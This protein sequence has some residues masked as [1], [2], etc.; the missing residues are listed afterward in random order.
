MS[1]T[2]FTI[3]TDPKQEA[4][5]DTEMNATETPPPPA[6]NGA[7]TARGRPFEPGTSGNP[8]G[9]PKGHR[10]KATLAMEELLDGDAPALTRKVIERALEG[11]MV[12]M[13]LC[14]DRVMPPRRDRPVAFEL[15]KI[16]SAKDV[17]AAGAAILQA[18]A[19]GALSPGEAA[20]II[21]LLST[22][23]RMLEDTEIEARMAA[24]EKERTPS[25]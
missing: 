24:L 11:D 15:P 14:L 4:K 9:R 7:P 25:P 12:A 16:E 8:N 2:I 21:G 6:Q 19:D 10:N 3:F 5:L 22:Y 18:C 23:A 17:P 20:E 13:R 1:A